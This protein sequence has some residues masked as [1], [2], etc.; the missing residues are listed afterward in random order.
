LARITSI[1]LIL[2]GAVFII[3]IAADHYLIGV[4]LLAVPGILFLI[5]GSPVRI[6][7]MVFALQIVLTITQLSVVSLQVG[8]LNLRVDDILTLLLTWLW[9]LSLPDRSMKGIRIGVQGKFIVLFLLMFGFSAYR[10]LAAGNDTFFISNQLKPYGA[11]F[12]YFP[13]LWVLSDEGS[14]KQIWNVLLTSAAIGGLVYMIKGYSGTGEN[15]YFRD[16][17]GI[18]IATRQPNAIGAILMMFLG[19]LWKNWKK[20]PPLIITIPV[21]LLMGG[22]I[23][24][25]QTR[26]IWG[27]I[28]LALAAAWILNLFR[29]KDN[30]KLG[31]KL[32]V[33]LTVISVL[34]ILVVFTIS[35]LGILSA[36]N[37]A[38]RTGNETGSYL[39]DASSVARII[40][41]STIL[42]DL[43]GPVMIMG[44]G[45][46]VE[47]TCFRPDIGGIVSVY[48]VDSS[49]FQIA[50]NMGITGVIAFLGIF[51]VTLGRAAGLFIRTDSSRRY[52][53]K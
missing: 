21:I 36:S 19:R 27:G 35:T 47:Y 53:S 48:Y 28:I 30:V 14:Y 26:G 24:L 52:S 13:L 51:T 40:A 22:G 44:K 4:L 15:V 8:I 7:M 11:Y 20:K 18:R 37:I 9:I 43:N 25:S 5:M 32:I 2:I 42:E 6:L 12:L 38:R 31:R 41:W 50:L 39:T 29:K 33:T 23:I 1:C 16:T 49:Y 46:G 45:L 3:S 10:G 17:T 34:I